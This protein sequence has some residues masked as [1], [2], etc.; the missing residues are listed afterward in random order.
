MNTQSLTDLLIEYWNVISDNTGLSL[1]AIASQ[2]LLAP[3]RCCLKNIGQ[4]GASDDVRPDKVE[5]VDL[6]V[7][8]ILVEKAFKY[9]KDI[10]EILK[11]EFNLT[12]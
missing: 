10:S 4:V 5:E 12:I 8:E 3:A 2:A 11:N 7:E 9:L 1:K 6:S